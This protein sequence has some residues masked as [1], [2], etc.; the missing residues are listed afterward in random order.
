MAYDFDSTDGINYGASTALALTGDLTTFC[1][2]K[3]DTTPTGGALRAMLSKGGSTEAEE[4]NFLFIH[5][6]RESGGSVYWV[7]FHENGSGTNN[8]V[9]STTTVVTG[10]WLPVVCIRDATANTYQFVIDGS[11][12]SAQAYTN[13]PTGG[14]STTMYVGRTANA[15]HF[16]GCI[17][18]AAV[19]NVAITTAAAQS[20]CDGAS[21]VLVA[22]HGLKFYDP[23]VRQTNDVFGLV[24]TNTGATV[25]AHTRM[26]YPSKQKVVYVPVVAGIPIFRR[27]R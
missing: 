27:R 20:L 3:P 22:P 26:V 16:D 18:E 6:M 24:G 23:L 12:E 17:A 4:A 1:W 9:L 15:E 13:D 14:T 10:S 2:C 5:G 11:V 19:W 25:V 8:Q 21:P 7:A